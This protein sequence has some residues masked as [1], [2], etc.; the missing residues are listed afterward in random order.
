MKVNYFLFAG[1]L[2]SSLLFSGA[3]NATAAALPDDGKVTILTCD[4]LN[5]D[6]TIPLSN[7][8]IA[9]TNCGGTAKAI[10]IATCHANGRTSERTVET[11]CGGASPQPACTTPR[12]TEVVKGATIFTAR[13]NGGQVG[14]SEFD[15]SEC[16]ASDVAGKIPDLDLE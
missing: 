4:L 16:V 9:A 7:N 8:V 13:S 14:P 3:V 15:D 11:T 2:A 10:Q 5:E 1:A 12:A 6:V